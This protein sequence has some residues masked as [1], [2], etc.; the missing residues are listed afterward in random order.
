MMMMMMM[1]MMTMMTMMVKI[2]MKNSMLDNLYKKKLT[3]DIIGPGPILPGHCEQNH[4]GRDKERSEMHLRAWSLVITS[5]C[6]MGRIPQ[7]N[8][9]SPIPV[10]ENYICFWFLRFNQ[11]SI[12]H[13][14][15]PRKVYLHHHSTEIFFVYPTVYP[16]HAH[17]H[18]KVIVRPEKPVCRYSMSVCPYVRMSVC[19]YVWMY[20]C[21]SM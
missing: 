18:G 11:H 10:L 17:F 21:I 9:E 12:K 14:I 7:N 3:W 5:Q 15:K 6:R 20:G 2:N 4:H 1:M 13:S 16:T 19:L 8:N